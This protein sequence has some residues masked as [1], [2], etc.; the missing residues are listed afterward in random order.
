MLN[1]KVEISLLMK[2]LKSYLTI[3]NELTPRNTWV[4]EIPDGGVFMYD[5]NENGLNDVDD[6]MFYPQEGEGDSIF[7]IRRPF[8]RTGTYFELFYVEWD[9]REK[10]QRTVPITDPAD[11]DICRQFWEKYNFPF[12]EKMR[13]A[14][15]TIKGNQKVRL[16]EAL[17]TVSL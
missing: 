6:V 8:R 5:C 4:W 3:G 16:L 12:F 9:E 17:E 10:A 1:P 2:E 14:L 15:R 7:H 13:P 11:I